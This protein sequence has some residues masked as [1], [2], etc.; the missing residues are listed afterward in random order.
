MRKNAT[1]RVPGDKTVAVG[2]GQ[3]RRFPLIDLTP[4]IL[5][6]PQRSLP[7]FHEPPSSSDAVFLG[8][9]LNN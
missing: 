6:S 9:S 2:Q 7:E 3:E 4:L 5:V 8:R 1:R